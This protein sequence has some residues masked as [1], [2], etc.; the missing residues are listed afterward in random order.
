MAPKELHQ[1]IA[2]SAAADARDDLD[3]TV[4]LRGN[5]LAKIQ[6]SFYRHAESIPQVCG[7]VNTQTLKL[8]RELTYFNVLFKRLS[9]AVKAILPGI[10]ITTKSTQNEDASG[11][12]PNV[13]TQANPVT[14]TTG[15]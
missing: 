4:V 12:D 3:E 14:T 5:Q 9:V 7:Q 11:G 6:I 2:L 13:P 8:V 1:Q 10:A 15:K